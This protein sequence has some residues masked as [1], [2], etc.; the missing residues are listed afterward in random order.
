[1]VRRAGPR[2]ACHADGQTYTGANQLFVST[3][4]HADY[5]LVP[6]WVNPALVVLAV[7]AVTCLAYAVRLAVIRRRTKT[8]TS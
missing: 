3:K 2:G 8:R 1:M 7:L 5:D 4:C 6:G